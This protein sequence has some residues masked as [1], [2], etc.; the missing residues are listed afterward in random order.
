[1]QDE[2]V[3]LDDQR[4]VQEVIARDTSLETLL[5]DVARMIGPQ[6]GDPRISIR[7]FDPDRRT[8]DMVAGEG[9]S[10][11]FRRAMQGM[12]LES[13]AGTCGAAVV[14][15]QLAITERIAVDPRWQGLQALAR[16]EGLAACWS[17][18]VIS[19]EDE[20]LGTLDTYFATPRAPG[21]HEEAQLH[22]AA[23]LVALAIERHRDRRA[24]LEVEQ[25]F[26]SLFT[27]LPDAVFE[28]DLQGRFLSCNAAATRITGFSEAWLRGQ[29]YARFVTEEA[30]PAIDAAFARVCAGE[31]QQHIYQSTD[32][33]GR[34]YTLEVTNLPI[35]VDDRVVGVYGVGRDITGRREQEEQLR[36]L[37]R[38][39]DASRN[40]VVLADA[41]LPDLP[42][43]FV[44]ET[45]LGLTGYARDELIGHNCRMLQGPETDPVTVARLR[46]AVA[47]RSEIQVTLRNYRKDGS[48]FWNHLYL[49]PVLDDEGRCTHIIGIQQ[50]VSRV[51]EYEHR[52]AHQASHDALTGLPNR[53]QFVSRLTQQHRR[54]CR[55]NGFLA[56]LYID[57]DDFKPVNDGLG[58][59][60]GDRLL[61]QV[62]H[63]LVA[64]LD[65][66]DI[67]SR[68][69]SDEFALLLTSVE[70]ER[71]VL[72]RAEAILEALS[73]PFELEGH[74]LHISA[75][76]GIASSQDAPDQAAELLQSADLAMQEA[77]QQGRNTWQWYGDEISSLMSE[78]VEM[79]LELQE[80]IREGQ[81]LLHYQPIVDTRTGEVRS[82]EA[83]VRWR[84]PEKGMISPGLF[85]PLA[86]QTGQI[87]AIGRW[88]LQRACQDMA[89]LHAEGGPALPVAVNIS[90]LQF[91]RAGFLAQVEQVLET[92]GWPAERLELE[93]TEGVL[94]SGTDR[95]IEV[96][97]ALRRRGVRVAIDDF[98]SGFSSL[99]YLRQ[100]PISKVKLDRSF[101]HDITRNGDNA[102]IVQGVITM[103]HHLGLS[104]VAEGIEAPEQRLDLL[105]RDCDL[106]QGFLFS[107]PVPL[108]QLARLPARLPAPPA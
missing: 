92:S 17:V 43:V 29:P 30:L 54:T 97:H 37:A 98:G 1:M 9:F 56:L 14:T 27:R 7:V 81:F 87:V 57:L 77:K 50:D 65:Q 45:F 3:R 44:N 101:I 61:E 31:T 36:L 67:A 80:A 12:S 63:R 104:V 55:E 86:E 96:L 60:V 107:P 10:P 71:D 82:V 48:A 85:I 88:V 78:H 83:L 23:G 5:A 100:L 62:A 106:L 105:G 74:R 64:L 49:S 41:T 59:H 18:P 26:R 91:R 16:D 34:A 28:F 11:A 32:A 39:I 76:I 53:Q 4:A 25:R 75:S 47:E 8:L 103:A 89:R 24:R 21:E 22:R 19:A 90:P 72:A 79:R 70:D 2:S 13:P 6:L 68:L 94:M 84:H 42:L 51:R 69:G 95:A 58:H 20:L 40:G 33:E 93:V 52:L 99:R 102:A 38:G 108:D 73:R 46:A 15:R 66:G 35:I